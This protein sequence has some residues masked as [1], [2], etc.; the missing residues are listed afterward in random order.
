M[1]PSSWQAVLKRHR[2]WPILMMILRSYGQ[3]LFSASPMTGFL[4]IAGFGLISVKTLILSG[5]GSILS[6]TVACLRNPDRTLIHEGFFGFNGV[7]LGI[8]W[9][10]YFTTSIPS[11]ILFLTAALLVYPVQAALMDWLSMGRFNLPVMS[12]PAVTIFLVMWVA[13]YGISHHLYIIPPHELYVEAASLSPPA[14]DLFPAQS[15]GLLGLVKK[16]S[17]HVWAL[18]L[19]GIF[20]HSRMSGFAALMGVWIGML[21]IW[22]HPGHYPWSVPIFIG[23]NMLPVAVG[24][25]GNFLI[26]TGGGL[27]LTT[28]ALVFCWILWAVLSNIFHVLNFPVLTLP[29][30]ITTL[31]TL[32]AAKT[33]L[34]DKWSIIPVRLLHITTPEKMLAAIRRKNGTDNLIWKK[35]L[36]N[37]EKIRMAH[38]YGMLVKS[39]GVSMLCGAGTSTES[40]IPDFRGKG[41]DFWR[42]YHPEDFFLEN[43]LSSEAVR[44]KYWAMDEDFYSIVKTAQ[45]GDTHRFVKQLDAKGKLTCIVTQNVDG[46]FQKAGLSGDKLIEIHGTITTATCLAC[47]TPHNRNELSRPIKTGSRIPVCRKC[48]G[49]LK[50]DM[51]FMGETVSETKLNRALFQILSSDL[52]LVVGTTLT[53]EPVSSLSRMAKH[54]GV[55]VVI[56]NLSPTPLDSEADMVFREP[57]GLF[58]KRLEVLMKG[59]NQC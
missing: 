34:Y 22:F 44:A 36:K 15:H 8:F 31:F 23:F 51:V 52:L 3:L 50:P 38:F 24:L 35:P 42:K 9:S 11:C 57:A 21:L 46:L 47:G 32:V 18:I 19:A 25:W 5:I 53:V 33:I 49:T 54:K 30:N 27:V 13:I 59:K 20:I 26:G 4:I 41:S 10:W 58:F 40:G 37:E 29:F 2:F 1:N 45:P 43:F 55:R 48:N 16:T 14:I 39:R 28:V 6:S 17:L 12:L 7:L 56:I